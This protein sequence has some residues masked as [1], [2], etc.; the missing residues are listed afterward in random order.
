MIDVWEW[1]EP[2]TLAP[3]VHGVATIRQKVRNY[4]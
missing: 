2:T 1:I 3:G 4:Y